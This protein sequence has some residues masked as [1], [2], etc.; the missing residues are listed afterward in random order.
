[1][2]RRTPRLWLVLPALLLAPCAALADGPYPDASR[3]WAASEY[4]N[5]LFGHTNG[6]QALPHLRSPAS[7]AVFERLVDERNVTRIATADM[8]ATEKLRQL[9]LIISVTGEARAAYNTAVMVGEPLTGELTRVQLFALETIAATRRVSQSAPEWTVSESAW[10]T[11]LLG[12]AQSLAERHV[13]SAAER[14]ALADGILQTLPELG[15]L[16][17]EEDAL[18]LASDLHALNRSERDAALQRS[19]TQLEHALLALVQ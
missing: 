17:T 16:L 2:S 10:Q 14:R 12:V 11:T 19:Q 5:F 7:R 4:V 1:M 15:T 3:P 6:N 18:A 13:Y 9:G 8:P